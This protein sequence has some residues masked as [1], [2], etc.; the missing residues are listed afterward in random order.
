MAAQPYFIAGRY[1]LI[2]KIGEGGMGVVYAAYDR[3]NNQ[4]VALKRVTN[5]TG[6]S[7]SDSRSEEARLSLSREF[8]ALSALRHPNIIEVQD[9]GFDEAGQPYFTMALLQDSLSIVEAGRDLTLDEKVRLIV[10]S[11]SAL[12]YVHRRRIIHRDLKPSNILV[13]SDVSVKLLDFGL[14]KDL[15]SQSTGSQGGAV[16]G[17][18][19]HVAPEL[20][21]EPRP[22]VLT[23]LYAMGLIAYE[24]LTGKYPFRAQTIT[25]LITQILNDKPDFSTL[26]PHLSPVI[27]QMMAKDPAERYPSAE[28]AIAALNEAMGW[29]MPQQNVLMLDSL[30]QAS[31]FIGRNEELTT[32]NQALNAA[33]RGSGSVWLVAG[34]SGVGKSRLLAELRTQGLIRGVL[35]L[36]GQCMQDGGLKYQLWRGTVRRLL[37]TGEV[38]YAEASILKDIVPDIE[39]LLNVKIPPP[40]PLEGEA[41]HQRMVDTIVGLFQ[42][43]QQPILIILEDLQWASEG[44]DVLQQLN[45][46]VDNLPILIVG[47]FRDDEQADL[48]EQLL[49]APVLRLNR[50][51]EEEILMLSMSMLGEPGTNPQLVDLL[52]RETEGNPFFIVEVIRTL[53]NSAGSLDQIGHQTLPSHLVT[54]GMRR[55]LERRLSNLS[56]SF[57]DLL[58]L[59]AIAGRQLDRQMVE[60]LVVEAGLDVDVEMWL[61]DCANRA[62]LEAHEGIQWQFSHDKLREYLLDKF[63]ETERAAAYR[64][65]ALTYEAHYPDPVE[66][67]GFMANL[68]RYANDSE[69]EKHY[70]AIAAD[71]GWQIS[72]YHEAIDHYTRLYQLLSGTDDA[73]HSDVLLRLSHTQLQLDQAV[74]A[75]THAQLAL[76]QANQSGNRHNMARA[77]HMLAQIATMRGQFVEADGLL[78]DAQAALETLDVPETAAW[79]QYAIGD[80]QWRKRQLNDA[81]NTLIN[82]LAIT[83]DDAPQLRLYIL[84]RLGT[85]EMNQN[86]LNQARRYYGEGRE[87]AIQTLNRERQ[88][89]FENN[90]GKIALDVGNLDEAYSYFDSALALN[91]TVGRGTSMALNLFNLGDVLFRR[92][93]INGARDYMQRGLRTAWTTGAKPLILLGLSMFAMLHAQAEN[94]KDAM[95]LLR[96]VRVHP[97]LDMNTQAFIQHV[98]TNYSITDEE[99]ARVSSPPVDL[100]TL[101]QRLLQ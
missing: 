37:L 27:Q 73:D 4:S 29:E 38:T 76:D 56:D 16:V 66:R 48:P 17:T 58:K 64:L 92:G 93:N 96:A 39:K 69:R 33:R 8:R 30:L 55:V 18:L 11:L 28:S 19:M 5:F 89:A 83:P 81:L 90:L 44:L 54:G 43:Q 63:D 34:E 45:E 35:V 21:S 60:A 53:A 88:A 1:R 82:A 62:I 24:L 36:T 100:E 86:H 70:L 22:T 101:V 68:W 79:V 52:H 47:S 32:L 12:T 98:Q 10:D 49:G 46:I 6:E 65:V 77:L 31:R 40:P 42:G 15:L 3:L 61:T 59:A 97:S 26:P 78:T 95:E 99:L 9:Y 41:L 75:H 57:L 72:M 87:L 23:D 13:D 91:S 85:I 25:H 80:L 84:N 51:T 7:D 94:R 2:N 74:D 20:F 67:A 71:Q 50:L 14:A